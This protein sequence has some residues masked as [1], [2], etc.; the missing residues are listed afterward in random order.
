MSQLYYVISR[1]CNQYC[2]S[3]PRHQ[4]ERI[5]DENYENVVGRLFHTIEKFEVNHLILSGGEPTLYA[6]F[7]KLLSALESFEG[8]VLIQ[9]NGQKFSERDFSEHCFGEKNVSKYRVLTAVHSMVPEIHDHITGVPG[10]FEKVM[11]AI[12]VLRTLGVSVTVKCILSNLNYREL[13]VYINQL[14]KK[15]QA[16]VDFCLSGMDY[17]GMND[18]ERE[19]YQLDY[20]AAVPFIEKMIAAN[21]CSETGMKN[22]ALIELPLCMMDREYWKYYRRTW[23]EEQIYQ[24]ANMNHPTRRNHDFLPR[25]DECRNCDL[26]DRCPGIWS[27][28]YRI[29]PGCIH[30]IKEESGEGKLV[31]RAWL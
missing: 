14:G 12:S 2:I 4:E 20:Q 26:K 10:S 9:S 5:R 21:E 13:P 27:E 17:I 29:H 7:P 25:Q 19:E 24:D 18:Q 22:I 15:F 31:L 30:P 23:G 3:C 6:G 11:R 8:E 28:H 1:N 16:D